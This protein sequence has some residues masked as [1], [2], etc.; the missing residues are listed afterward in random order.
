MATTK[1]YSSIYSV[2]EFALNDLVPKYFGSDVNKLNIGL[3]GYTTEL[4]SNTTEDT[5]NAV[6]TF[7]KEMFPNKA[8]MPESLYTYASLY[9]LENLFAKPAR[10]GIMLFVNESD[11]IKYSTK[12]GNQYEFVLDSDMIIDIEGKQFMLD[13][14]ILITTKK[15]KNDY[16]FMATYQMNF[17]NSISTI[18]NPYIKTKRI[19]YSNSNYLA[20]ITNVHQLYKTEKVENIINNDKINFPSITVDFNNQLANF[21]VY[22][23]APN[24]D[25]YIQLTKRLIGSPPLKEPFCYYQLKN[26]DSFEISFSSRD[27]YFQPRFNSEIMIHTYTTDGSQGNF[28]MYTGTDIIVKP[29]SDVYEYNNSIALFAIAQTASEDGEDKLSLDELRNIIIEKSSTVDSYTNEN[30][31][32]LYFSN[33]KYKYG[34]EIMFIKKRDDALERLFSAYALLK[35]NNNDIY[36]TNTAHLNLVE[37]DFDVDY[38]QSNRYL[39]KAGHLFRYAGNSRDTLEIIPNMNLNDDLSSLTEPFIYTNPFLISV[40]KSPSVIGFYMNSIDTKLGLE[41]SYV[42]SDSAVQFICNNLFV[43]RNAL[44]G[45]DTYKLSITLTPT[46]DL[47]KPIVD[48][49]TKDDLGNLK[50]KGMIED[51]TGHEFCYLDFVLVNADIDSNLYTYEAY[52]TTDDY[53]TLT[54]KFRVTGLKDI[55]TMQEEIK[56]IPMNDC[57]LN[58]YTF[59]KYDDIVIN[60]QYSYINDITDYTMTNKYSTIDNKINFIN[61]LNIM[62]S[63]LKFI[64]TGEDVYMMNLSFMPFV[65]AS[66]LKNPAVYSHFMNNLMIQ[67]NYMQNVLNQIT[68]NYSIDLKF[69]NTFGRSK[70]FT[71]GEDGGL[72]DRVNCKIKF[73]VKATSGAILANL[74]RDLKIFI[75]NYIETINNKGSNGIYVSNLIRYIE[76]NFSGSIEYLKFVSINEYDSSVQIIENK[77]VDIL[78]MT[79][80]DRKNFVPEYLTISTNDISIEII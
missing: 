62:R 59:F 41:Y 2:K 54:Q 6:S 75:K 39:L 16:I 13:Y 80:E 42:N 36:P 67:Y 38:E 31:L 30:D 73:K 69:Y 11:I 58:I 3:L 45:E 77:T 1:D 9:K 48:P 7:I 52:I 50:I 24:S 28:E 34:N 26:D 32:Q 4:I 71:A 79:K 78:A 23:K 43:K 63:Q 19:K 35:D 64:K 66:T 14:D 47:E 57:V 17:N 37:S 70:N 46:I 53:M 65:K 74:A 20:L 18:K 12:N 8:M 25:E 55:S 29:K 5:F 27:N 44:I 56:L 68:N 61:P 15:Y 76:E 33:F 49:T 51:S 22:Y 10:L 60:H 40:G 21:E 72:L